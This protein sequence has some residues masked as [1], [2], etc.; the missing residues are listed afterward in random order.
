MVPQRYKTK[1]GFALG[2]WVSTQ[3]APKAKLLLE[4]VQLLDTLG[5]TWDPLAEKWEEGFSKLQQ[6][7][8]REGDC[9][10]PQGHKEGDFNLGTWVGKQRYTK[11]KL[12]PER[13][14]RLDALGFF[15][16]AHD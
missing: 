10:V 6:F 15:W 7:K 1:G 13:K 12:I 8:E 14:Q 9:R 11:D 5:F 16:S 4:Y 3:R 2:Q